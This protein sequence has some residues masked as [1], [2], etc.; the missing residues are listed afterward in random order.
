MSPE[1]RGERQE[2]LHSAGSL[3]RDKHFGKTAFVRAVVEVSNFCR[4]DCSYCA[5]RR[6]N[7]SLARRRLDPE[8]I[9]DWIAAACPPTVTDINIQSGEDPVAVREVILPLI[10]LLKARTGYGISVCPGTLDPKIS[11]ELKDAG[12]DF[13]VIKLETADERHY[14]EIRAPGNFAE[15]LATIRQLAADGWLVSSGFIL[16]VPGEP[17]D[18][19][20]RALGLLSELPLAGASVSPFIPGPETPLAGNP[21]GNLEDVLNCV[22]LMRLANPRR[23]IPA[24]SAMELGSPGTYARALSAGANLA[25][26]NLTPAVFR[27][28]YPIYTQ[29]RLIMDEERVLSAISAAGLTPSRTGISEFLRNF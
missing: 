18:A 11:R 23:I 14:A 5:M 24:V 16:G 8:K 10:A 21:P 19:A 27:D 3:A 22:A 17:A 9:F 28:E 4:E 26:I 12:A 6:S 1:C 2:A 15:R 29:D 7:R 20:Q 13:Y 25:T